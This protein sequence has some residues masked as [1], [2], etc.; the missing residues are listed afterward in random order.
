MK[1]N[2]LQQMMF[3]ECSFSWLSLILL[4]FIISTYSISKIIIK[5]KNESVNKILVIEYLSYRWKTKNDVTSLKV[6]AFKDLQI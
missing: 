2:M 3:W 6:R 4:E 5:Y 1:F